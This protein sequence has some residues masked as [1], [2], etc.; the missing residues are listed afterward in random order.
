MKGP[1]RVARQ[2][3]AD[4]RVLVGRIIVEDGMNRLASRDGG[5][6]GVQEADELTVAMALHA[7]AEHGSFQ[8]VEHGKQCG[9]AVA[10]VTVGLGGGAP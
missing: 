8:D 3:G 2:P 7:A 4:L 6:D 10:G 1:A 5:L 9:G